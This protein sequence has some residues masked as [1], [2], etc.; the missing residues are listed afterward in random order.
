MK[1]SELLIFISLLSLGS[2][3]CVSD[4]L[5]DIPAAYYT[6]A[7]YYIDF[8]E[9]NLKLWIGLL[10]IVASAIMM[11]SRTQGK[12]LITAGTIALTLFL[13]NP[14]AYLLHDEHQATIGE[15]LVKTVSIFGI[16]LI[17]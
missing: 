3:I 13:A 4:G 5:F 7:H 9:V 12:L 15:I 1:F 6:R 11:S 16:S 14:A 10:F 2:F 17:R 8:T